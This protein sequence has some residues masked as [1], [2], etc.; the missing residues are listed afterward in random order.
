MAG[1]ALNGP[2]NLTGADLV[3]NASG[4]TVTANGN[5]V[6][7]QATPPSDPPHCS[8]APPVILPP[9][10]APPLDELTNVWVVN[11]FNQMVK[12]GTKPIV[13]LGMAMEG[14]K[15]GGMPTWPGMVQP[16]E[17]NSGPK[18]VT[19]NQVPANVV[20]DRAVIFPT[21]APA[22]LSSSGQGA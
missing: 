20:N 14:G 2:L 7:V 13:A 18:A 1:L 6:L 16:S 5:E 22:T 9:P 15:V 21:G 19:V 10:P 11:S 8:T 3:L 17:K 12:V 4:G